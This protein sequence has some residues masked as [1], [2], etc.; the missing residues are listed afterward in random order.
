MISLEKAWFFRQWRNNIY[1]LSCIS[2]QQAPSASLG[3]PLKGAPS[4]DLKNFPTFGSCFDFLNLQTVLQKKLER[5][6]LF[7]YPVF[8]LYLLLYRSACM[9]SPHGF[10][11]CLLC[12]LRLIL[13]LSQASHCL[14]VCHHIFVCASRIYSYQLHCLFWSSFFLHLLHHYEE[15]K[16]NPKE[17]YRLLWTFI[18]DKQDSGLSLLHNQSFILQSLFLDRL[19]F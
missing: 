3:H 16:T 6:I 17:F 10:I 2:G 9:T 1:F 19:C 14:F 11:L 12:K 4:E 5:K 8:W 13:I 7:H 15:I 18:R